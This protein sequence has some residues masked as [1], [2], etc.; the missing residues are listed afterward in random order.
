MTQVALA[1]GE[2][3]IEIIGAQLRRQWVTGALL[4]LLAALAGGVLAVGFS[5]GISFA[6]VAGAIWIVLMVDMLAGGLLPIILHR[7]KMDPILVSRPSLAVLALLL[8][9]PLLIHVL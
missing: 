5:T 3:V 1:D 9:V 2:T 7:L 8:G 6:P 4:G